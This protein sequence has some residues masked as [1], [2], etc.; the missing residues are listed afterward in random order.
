MPL[1]HA[2][3]LSMFPINSYKAWEQLSLGGA[4]TINDNVVTPP[5]IPLY[6][7]ASLLGKRKGQPLVI[8]RAEISVSRE[9]WT[10]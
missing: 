10:T 2:R 9:R 5:K 7:L 6:P 1:M 8:R 4:Y 3:S